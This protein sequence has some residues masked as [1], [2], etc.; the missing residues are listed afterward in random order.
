MRLGVNVEG[1]VPFYG[2][3]EDLYLRQL[4]RTLHELNA[5]EIVLFTDPVNHETFEGY[6][7]VLV[8]AGGVSSVER[9]V[10]SAQPDVVFSSLW[11]APSTGSAPQVLYA[12]DLDA[13][14]NGGVR[15]GWFRGSGIGH[16]R[17]TAHSAVAMV[18][19]SKF[20]QQECLRLL[21]LAMDRVVVAPLGADHRPAQPAAESVAQ[22]PF[23]LSTG[24]GHELDDISHI[25]AVLDRLP[26]LEKHCLV[27]VGHALDEETR[28][29]GSRVLRIER[30]PLE[31]LLALY[32]DCDL[33]IYPA[34]RAGSAV[35]VLR[36]M[37]AGARVIAPKVGGIPEAAG[38]APIYFEPQNAAASLATAVQRA[39]R[40]SPE[41]RAGRI[42][43]GRQTAHGFTWESCAWKTLSALRRAE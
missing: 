43:F 3:T 42:K 15:R 8:G 26:E 40:E 22:E 5:A 33:Y 10:K 39:L 34:L 9:A 32:R 24:E 6:E 18:V 27:V 12:L 20:V 28:Q 17:K 13:A 30:L 1:I 41:E 31:H 25:Q 19:P 4:V 7:R 21:D 16:L 11:N 2:G 35:G 38:S 29:W 14:E 23:L 36:A 37:D